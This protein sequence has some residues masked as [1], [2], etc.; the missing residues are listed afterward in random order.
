[1]ATFLVVNNSV[2]MNTAAVAATD[3]YR[4]GVLVSADATKNKAATS[5]G[6]Q[7]S[8]G[9]FRLNT[10]PVEYMNATAG[11][12]TQVQWCNGLP[13]DSDGALCVSTN[14]AATYSNGIPFAAN[15]AVAV[16]IT[17]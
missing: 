7:F 13:L 4:G 11:L 10:G 5:A 17:P 9:L 8:N 1:M 14:S 12:P 15:G 3:A 16:T 2:P 6:S